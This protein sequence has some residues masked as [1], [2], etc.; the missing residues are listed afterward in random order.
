MF[1]AVAA[2][3]VAALVATGCTARGRIAPPEPLDSWGRTGHAL[4]ELF[5]PTGI[6][7][8]LDG[9]VF[10]ADT[11]NDR[12]QAFDPDGAFV[13][14]FGESGD[15]PGQF[16]RPMDLDVDAVGQVY[17]AELG[18][19][20]IQ[21]FTPRGELVRMLRGEGTP[22]GS[23]DG[24]A[25]VLVTPGGEIY[26]ADFYGHR[27]VRFDSSGKYL[28]VLGTPGRILAG[29]L[30]YPTDLAWLPNRLVVADAYN[31]RVQVMTPEGDPILRW[32]GPLGLG[33]AGSRAGWFR[34][35][36]GIAVD[37]SA[38]VYVAD[39]ENH[40]VQVFDAE[41]RLLS[42]F[43]SQGRELGEF[44]RPTDLDIAADGR[45]YVV[46]FG[47]DRI[48]VFSPLGHGVDP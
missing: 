29:R 34:V 32:G 7:V 48:Q 18:G 35:A 41:G 43:G 37:T 14:S 4:G 40:R 8:G 2:V 30:H 13:R 42:S 28:G 19:D 15:D 36:T 1:S 25:G 21:V 47:N 9:T 12:I 20:R 11:G 31:N 17:V 39:F 45:I 3:A 6:A 46:D 23:F 27:I 26:V 16:R 5:R 22:A 44:E 10:V 24:A 33:I 38:R